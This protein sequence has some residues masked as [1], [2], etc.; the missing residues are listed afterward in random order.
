MSPRWQTAPPLYLVVPE[1]NQDPLRNHGSIGT[2]VVE[3]WR[4][5]RA[6]CAAPGPEPDT[7]AGSVM[8]YLSHLSL[9][10]RTVRQLL[11][12]WSPLIPMAWLDRAQPPFGFNQRRPIL[13]LCRGCHCSS[14]KGSP[15]LRRW[16]N[17]RPTVTVKPGSRSGRV[18]NYS[19]LYIRLSLC[20]DRG[21]SGARFQCSGALNRQVSP[22]RL[23]V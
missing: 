4:S 7:I 23:E 11:P 5:S 3:D 16:I 2:P 17:L 8:P 19:T 20:Q 12:R 15:R 21:V 10:L 6:P 14:P 9:S 18:G 1:E 13:L 22:L